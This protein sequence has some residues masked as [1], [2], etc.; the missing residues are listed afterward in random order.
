MQREAIHRAAAFDL[1]FVDLQH[2]RCI[3]R[4]HRLR[5]KAAFDPAADHHP[6]ELFDVRARDVGRRYVLAVAQH[7]NAVAHR[8]NLVEMMRDEDH[9][10]ALPLQLAH[11]R[12]QMLGLGRRERGGGFVEDQMRASSDSALPIS[13]NCCCATDSARIGASRSIATPSRAKIAAAA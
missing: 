2:A 5:R 6:H 4:A 11:D 12:E 13:T 1:Q 3:G 9:R 10:D 7:G 8:E